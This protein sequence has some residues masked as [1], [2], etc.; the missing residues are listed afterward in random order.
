M[1]RQK[2]FIAIVVCLVILSVVKGRTIRPVN[3][4]ATADARKLLT[5]LYNLPERAENRLISGHLAGGSIGPTVPKNQEREK[6]GYR[7]TMSEIEY[8]HEV[9]GQWVGLI[10]ADYCAGWI[11]C[12]NPVVANRGEID[13]RSVHLIPRTSKT[14]NQRILRSS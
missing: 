13:W 12:P 3:P 1:N 6:G 8:L 5:Y 14:I 11:E 10:G 4:Y 7:F 9:S 2:V